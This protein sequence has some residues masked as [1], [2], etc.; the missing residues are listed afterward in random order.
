[1]ETDPAGVQVEEVA[2][3]VAALSEAPGFVIAPQDDGGMEM[4][5]VVVQAEAVVDASVA[6]F[7]AVLTGQDS[8]GAGQDASGSVS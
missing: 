3:A 6:A 2:G 4:N 1:M 5:P 8:A 7:M